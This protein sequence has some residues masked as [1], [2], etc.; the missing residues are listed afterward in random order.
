MKNTDSDSMQITFPGGMAVESRYRGFVVRTDQPAA[1]GGRGDAPSPFDLFLSSLGT[2]AG[3][4]ALRFCQQR[5]L[6]T[7]GLALELDFERA[8]D[9]KAVAL[10]SIALQPPEGFPRKYVSAIVRAVDQCTVR[11]HLAAPPRFATVVGIPEA[12]PPVPRVL[13]PAVMEA[14]MLP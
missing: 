2:C 5:G 7:D 11:R 12:S 1:A 10:V 4:Y 3:Y 14:A 8:A 6:A 9:G 13:E